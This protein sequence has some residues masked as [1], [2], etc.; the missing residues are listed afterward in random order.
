MQTNTRTID[1][2]IYA[3]YATDEF[4]QA[5]AALL[6]GGYR[7]ILASEWPH[8]GVSLTEQGHQVLH[9]NCMSNT[10]ANREE[11]SRAT[12]FNACSTYC[13]NAP[14]PVTPV[15]GTL[16]DPVAALPDTPAKDKIK[17]PKE[18][19]TLLRQHP[20]SKFTRAVIRSKYLV[21]VPAEIVEY[22]AIIDWLT[23]NVPQGARVKCSGNML[24]ASAPTREETFTIHVLASG[25][26]TGRA[27]V[28]RSFSSS[29][30]VEVPRSIVEQGRYAII[31]YVHQDFEVWDR[32]RYDDDY[33]VDYGNTDWNDS[34]HDTEIDDDDIEDALQAVA[35]DE[36]EDEDED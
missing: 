25:T 1:G 3:D 28:S 12:M 17:L 5:Y 8:G 22:D 33:D 30:T 35:D 27:Y 31:D 16:G 21:V 20:T 7:M 32:A 36:N 4:D 2:V 23:E 6:P 24:S 13:T 18:L 14:L 10:W 11:S 34:D 29:G 9:W 15:T 26:E 19:D